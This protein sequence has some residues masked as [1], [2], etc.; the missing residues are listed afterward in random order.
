MVD[1]KQALQLL[2]ILSNVTDHFD[3]VSTFMGPIVDR[4][5]TDKREGSPEV[6]DK[7]LLSTRTTL[8][9]MLFKSISV[10]NEIGHVADEIMESIDSMGMDFDDDDD[11]LYS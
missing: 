10:H 1:G 6:Q 7:A 9:L 8:F 4:Y 2:T 3:R 5:I 11:E